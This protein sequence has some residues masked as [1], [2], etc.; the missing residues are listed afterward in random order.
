LVIRQ[1]NTILLLLLLFDSRLSVLRRRSF[2]KFRSQHESKAIYT[3]TSRMMCV[4]LIS[5]IFCS[6]M[7]EGWPGSNW[8][9]WSNPFLA[10]PTTPT[11][12]GTIFV[13]SFHILLNSISRSL[14]YYYYYYY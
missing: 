6:C 8:R 3:R 11:I 10:I 7:A 9:F 5:V 1:A 12:I 13:L 2:G 14:Y 4:V